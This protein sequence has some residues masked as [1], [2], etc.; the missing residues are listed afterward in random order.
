MTDQQEVIAFLSDGAAYG[1]PGEAVRVIETHGA[2]VFLVGDEAWKIKK[3]VKFRY[4]DFSTLE[5]REQVCRREL[6]INRPNAPQIY[7]GVVPVTREADGTLA[8]GGKGEPVEWAVHMRRFPDDALLLEQ[9]RKAQLDAGLEQRLCEVI[10]GFHA[11][12]PVLRDTGFA[13]RVENIIGSLNASFKAAHDLLPNGLVQA[14]AA[15]ADAALEASTPVLRQREAAGF[16]RRCHGD[17]HL[18]NIVVLDG[19]PVL[20]D[21]IEFSEELATIDVL[22]DVAFVLMDLVHEE[23]VAAANRVLNGYLRGSQVAGIEGLQ[24]LALLL[25]L[26]AGVRAM[27]TLDRAAQREGRQQ[28]EDIETA[29]GYLRQ[30]VDCLAPCQPRLVAVGGFSGTG[31]TTVAAALAPALRPVPGALHLRTDVERKLMAGVALHERLPPE[32]Y[33]KQASDEVYAAVFSKARAALEAGW[34]VVVDAAFL[35]PAERDDMEALARQCGAAFAGLWL[36]ADEATLVARVSARTGDASDATADV[37][38]KQLARGAGEIGWA[39]ID[40]GG[41]QAR[42]LERCRA[43]LD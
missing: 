25:G 33:T 19:E 21:A 13:G 15:R 38:R 31:K 3:P 16:V 7:L 12:A 39:R 28:Q 14:F 11:R 5:R 27:V 35:D 17:L 23:Q 8:L 24:A 10:A 18:A 9:V 41:T 42:T 30:A 40:G 20:F 6:D 1:L 36:E 22:Y 37:V 26:R 34:P 43:A 4:M 2:L 32:S 29:A